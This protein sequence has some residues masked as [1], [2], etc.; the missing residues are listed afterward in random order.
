MRFEIG[1]L[2]KPSTALLIGLFAVLVLLVVEQSRTISGPST[3]WPSNSPDEFA[4]YFQS[5]RTV[6]GELAPTY[7]PGYRM[8]AF[9]NLIAA[10]K[11]GG[12][13]I[14]PWV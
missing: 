9:E 2:K 7:K 12:R 6:E 5:I 1:P 8:G 3:T 4:N 11:G 14:L 13:L 10:A